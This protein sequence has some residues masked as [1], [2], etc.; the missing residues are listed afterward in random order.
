MKLRDA[1]AMALC[2]LR[3]SM[4]K[5]LLTI[6]G[7]GVGVASVLTVQALGAAG[8]RQVE[9]EI[10]RMGVNKVWVT[11]EDADTLTAADVLAAGEAAQLPACAGA[12]TADVVS[13]GGQAVGAQVAGYDPAMQTVH[14][15]V[16]VEG[17]TFIPAD[18]SRGNAVCLV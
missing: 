13:F 2:S 14:G 12:C 6:L 18:Y 11:P 17:R 1:S 7:L 4:V 9:A 3:C 16:I 10:A 5:T 15:G 8:E